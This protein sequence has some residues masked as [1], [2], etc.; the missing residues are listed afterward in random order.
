MFVC[1]FPVKFISMVIWSHVNNVHMYHGVVHMYIY[2][3]VHVPTCIV[4]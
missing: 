4:Y 3:L 2:G 1:M